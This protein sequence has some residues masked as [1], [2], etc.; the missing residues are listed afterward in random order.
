MPLPTKIEDAIS[1]R[2]RFLLN[3]I[4]R[5][6]NELIV[7]VVDCWCG[8]NRGEYCRRSD[9]TPGRGCSIHSDRRCAAN[10]WKKAN[11]AEWKR[12]KDAAFRWIVRHADEKRVA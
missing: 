1:S 7:D 4:A 2:E 8:A 12:L 10:R 11:P 3:C 9:G 6:G 5:A